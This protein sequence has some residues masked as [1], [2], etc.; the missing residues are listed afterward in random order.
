MLFFQQNFSQSMLEKFSFTSEAAQ[1]SSRSP[2][3]FSEIAYAKKGWIIYRKDVTQLR[4]EACK[5]YR[6]LSE[7]EADGTKLEVFRLE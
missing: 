6:L 2:L 4:P 7:A 3:S 1:T 5:I